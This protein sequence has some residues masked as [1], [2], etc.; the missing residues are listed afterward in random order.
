MFKDAVKTVRPSI[1][2]ICLANSITDVPE[3]IIIQSLGSRLEA[4]AIAILFSQGVFEHY[5][6]RSAQEIGPDALN[7]I[8]NG[9]AKDT[10]GLIWKQHAMIWSG[11]V[12]LGLLWI[13][14]ALTLITGFDYFKKALPFLKDET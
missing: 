7:N 1:G 3:A 13:A 4:A 14:A 5:L 8:L 12:G 10:L 2:F 11:N 9:A 6:K